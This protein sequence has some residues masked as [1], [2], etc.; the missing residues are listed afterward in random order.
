[1]DGLVINY[2]GTGPT[3]FRRN[4][5]SASD[6]AYSYLFLR[7]VVCRRFVRYLSHSRTVLKSFDRFICHFTGPLLEPMDTVSLCQMRFSDCP[8]KERF[9]SRNFSPPI[10]THCRRNNS[11]VTRIKAVTDILTNQFI[12]CYSIKC[13]VRACDMCE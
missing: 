5:S 11:D 12:A 1:M 2:V 4:H 9:G 6:F 8:G 10:K 13:C 3:D 7:S